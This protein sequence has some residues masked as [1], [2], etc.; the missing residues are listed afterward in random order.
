MSSAG[1]DCPG[2]GVV[3]GPASE[4]GPEW[5]FG[6]QGFVSRAEAGCASALALARVW[7]LATVVAGFLLPAE[8]W[9]IRV[10]VSAAPRGALIP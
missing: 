10:A 1:P 9:V 4:L 2:V 6:V 7:R 8:S 5:A 3:P